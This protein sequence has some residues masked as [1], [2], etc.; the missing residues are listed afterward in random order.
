MHFLYI[1]GNF[2][3]ILSEAILVGLQYLILT[4]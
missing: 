1:I 4:E 2:F 3:E